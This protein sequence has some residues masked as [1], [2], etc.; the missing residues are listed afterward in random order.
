MRGDIIPAVRALSDLVETARWRENVARFNEQ[1]DLSALYKRLA[2]SL[3]ACR[4]QAVLDGD[5]Y[6]PEAW[7]FVDAGRAQL[8]RV[9]I[10]EGGRI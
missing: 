1:T 10:L 2:D 9:A 8:A 4:T 7:A 6:A 3:D 5:D